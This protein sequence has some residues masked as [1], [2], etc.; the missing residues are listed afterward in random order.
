MKNQKTQEKRSWKKVKLTKSTVATAVFEYLDK[1]GRVP[2]RKV[3]VAIDEFGN[4]SI[5]EL[6]KTEQ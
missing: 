1:R 6:Q 5:K 2:N 4:A 3:G